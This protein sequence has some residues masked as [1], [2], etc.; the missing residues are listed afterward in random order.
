MPLQEP[1]G[2]CVHTTAAHVI[3][4]Y[5]RTHLHESLTL[6]IGAHEP[7]FLQILSCSRAAAEGADG[8]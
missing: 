3:Y 7:P 2:I 1:D 6:L 4:P 8:M 5:A